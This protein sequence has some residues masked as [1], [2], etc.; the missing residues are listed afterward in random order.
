VTEKVSNRDGKKKKKGVRG[1]R[2]LMFPE[3]S[4]HTKGAENGRKNR[5]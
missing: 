1:G 5:I 3:K 4:D 2:I